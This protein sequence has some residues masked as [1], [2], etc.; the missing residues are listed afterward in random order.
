MRLGHFSDRVTQLAD[1]FIPADIAANRDQR[2]KARIF[3]YSHIFGPFIGNTVP[4]S[5]CLFD[6]T[7]DYRVIVLSASISGFW[8]FLPLLRAFGQ[9]YLLSILSVQNLIFSILWSCYWYG[10]LSSP[11][12]AWILTI[13]LLAFM[14]VGHSAR[15]RVVLI[16]QFV[17]NTMIYYAVC[18]TFTPPDVTL[19]HWAVQVFGLVSTGAAALYVTMMAFF[20]ANAL[21]S[22]AELQTEMEQHLGTA[23]DL[24]AATEEARRSGTAK[25]DFIARM[26][27]ELRAPL[28]AIIGYSEMLLEDAES[29]DDATTISDLTRIRD[30]GHY[31]LKLVNKILDLSR[32]EAGKMDSAQEW[33]DCNEVV[34]AVMREVAPLAEKNGDALSFVKQ[35]DL[36]LIRVDALK[37]KQAL[38]HILE[39]AAQYTHN[40]TITVTASRSQAEGGEQISLSVADTGPGIARERLPYLLNNFETLD[41]DDNRSAGGAGL[42]LAL[43]KKLCDLVNAQLSV[44]S[45]VGRGS[46]FTVTLSAKDAATSAAHDTDIAALAEE[47]E[48]GVRAIAAL[49]SAMRAEREKSE[50]S[51]GHA[52]AAAG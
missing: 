37:L 21:A 47:A 39:N 44:E 48:E 49:A 29:D 38:S 12:V 46:V 1:W 14:Y 20:Y 42:G 23:A 40:G 41:D 51:L 36:G 2:E 15:M 24:L 22:Q 25:S 33:V 43:S 18:A 31:L 34:V 10:G 19:A 50:R 52:K 17:V 28:N 26:S 13:P 9:Y 45:E 8:L 32:L 3:L 35:D 7:I 16:A 30:A 5:V 11:T 4:L 6:K 27:H